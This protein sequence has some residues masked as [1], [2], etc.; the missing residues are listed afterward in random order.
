[1]HISE[2]AHSIQ[3]EAVT[4]R[5]ELHKRAE[6]SFDE[7]KTASYIADYLEKLGLPVRKN[8]AGT[9]VVAFLDA[10]YK[11]SLLLRADM[12]A[13]PVT[14]SNDTEYRSE[15]EGV[16]HACGHDAHMAILLAAAKCMLKNKEDLKTNVL[17]VFQPGEETDGGAEPMIKTGILEEFGVT[18]AAGLHVMND[19]ETGKIQIKCGELMAA[20]DDFSL[21]VYG[22]GGHGAYPHECI[23][24]IALSA[25]IISDFDMISA[26]FTS[27]LAPKVISTCVIQSGNVNNVIPDSAYMS[28]TVRTFDNTL[29]RHIPEMM[30][31]AVKGICD[32]AGATYDF[33]FNYSYPPLIN[34]ESMANALEN[35][36]S[37][38]LGEAC[39][40]KGGTPSMGGDDFSYFGQHVPSVYFFLGSGNEKSGITMPLHST[41]F[42]IDESC[43]ETGVAAYLALAST[44]CIYFG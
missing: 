22:K 19:V 6:L 3:K 35:A 14:E 20:P 44:D 13:L 38:E 9:G 17:F 26:R 32:I 34:E 24:P 16:M 39:I 2:T 11:H 36:V 33:R 43:L 10:G 29:R 41:D 21:T 28:G 42:Q 12:D 27:P 31:K 8:V 23:D 30:E 37:K 40:V 5:R 4:L 7:H 1:M 25:R 18:C 15:T